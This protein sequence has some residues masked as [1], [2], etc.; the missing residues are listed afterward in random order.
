MV[1][2]FDGSD[3][4]NRETWLRQMGSE[5]QKGRLENASSLRSLNFQTRVEGIARQR[6]AR[7]ISVTL[8]WA[9]ETIQLLAQMSYEA[10]DSLALQW[11]LFHVNTA[12]FFFPQGS[13]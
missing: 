13:V 1:A 5:I 3:E 9:P 12:F 10:V 2:D 6:S 7:L 11:R 8:F 4:L